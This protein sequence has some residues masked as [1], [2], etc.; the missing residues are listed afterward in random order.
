M[1]SEGGE[2]GRDSGNSRL[3]TDEQVVVAPIQ[4]R[5]GKVSTHHRVMALK[6][7]GMGGLGKTELHEPIMQR[8]GGPL[9]WGNFEKWCRSQWG[10]DINFNVLPN[11]YYMIEFMKKEDIWNAKNKGPYTLDGI[12][13]HIIDWIP[14]FNPRFHTLPESIVW[15]RLYK[16][17]SNYWHIEII[18]DIC[19]ELGTFVSVNDVLEDRVWGSFIKICINTSQISKIPEEVK[20]IGADKVWIQRIDRE[21]QLHL[22]PHCFSRDHIG[23]ECEVSASILRSY[24]CVQTKLTDVKSYKENIEILGTNDVEQSSAASMKEVEINNHVDNSPLVLSG[25]Q[26]IHTNNSDSARALLNLLE[27]AKSFQNDIATELA[28]SL[29]LESTKIG[30]FRVTKDENIPPLP[31]DPNTSGVLGKKGMTTDLEEGEIASSTSEWEEDFEPIANLIMDNT[32]KGFGKTASYINAPNFKPKGKRG[33]KSRKTMLKI[34]GNEKKGGIQ[35][36]GTVQ[37]DF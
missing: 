7:F 24:A 32:V 15:L 10:E 27:D 30:K 18:K 31:V 11:D 6:S 34:A 25:Q 1:A 19:K 16:F 20:I 28:A 2:F 29:S 26:Q 37:K 33:H 5:G 12:G 22:C 17:P 36:I 21:D 14:N 8:F 9:L 23:L 3:L 4:G 13:V 35:R